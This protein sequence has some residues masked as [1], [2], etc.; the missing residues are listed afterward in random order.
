MAN[1]QQIRIERER[2]ER[3]F[4][5]EAETAASFL[6]KLVQGLVQYM[7]CPED[8]VY[9]AEPSSTARRVPEMD[10]LGTSNAVALEASG[11]VWT[12]IGLKMDSGPDVRLVIAV[13][14]SSN[15]TNN[16]DRIAGFTVD[17]GPSK[18]DLESV[19]YN[20]MRD[21]MLGLYSIISEAIEREAVA[22]V[23]R[24]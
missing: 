9:A 21:K 7:Q 15:A 19:T 6:K 12:T 2:A 16:A 3:E 8:N 13:R 11:R 14:K 18:G 22:M 23:R 10:I 20:E 4:Q 5:R 17:F 1:Y 24:V